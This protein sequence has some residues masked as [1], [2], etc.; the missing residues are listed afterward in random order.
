MFAQNEVINDSI[1]L[2]ETKY[3]FTILQIN[4]TTEEIHSVEFPSSN[5]FIYATTPTIPSTKIYS[6]VLPWSWNNY[7]TH[8]SYSGLQNCSEYSSIYPIGSSNEL[9]LIQYFQIAIFT[10]LP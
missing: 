10:F 3:Y 5:A 1:F 6:Q 4:Q 9:N 8:V 7:F 2:N